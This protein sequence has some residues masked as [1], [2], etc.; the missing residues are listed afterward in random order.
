MV[1]DYKKILIIKPSSLGDIVHTLPV[2]HALK[3]C[4][5]TCFIGWI[6]QRNFVHEPYD[7]ILDLHASFRSGLLGRTNP[8]GMRIGF[9]SARELNTWFQNQL[10]PVPDSVIHA[11]EKSFLFCDC[12]TCP[13]AAE[14]FYMCCLLEDS[15]VVQLFLRVHNV[16]ARDLIIYANPVTRWQKKFWSVRRW[17]ACAD[18]LYAQGIQTIFGGS[19]QDVSY[20]TSITR[21]MTTRALVTAGQFSLSQSV[22]LIQRC[23]LFVGL[24]SGSIRNV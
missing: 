8:G 2:V 23:A 10:V 3:R 13:V 16:A 24:N 14:D 4:F 1:T 6:V 22:A 19:A 21:M 7:C 5:S 12:L 11:L 18:R 15:D 20:I 9:R 17:A